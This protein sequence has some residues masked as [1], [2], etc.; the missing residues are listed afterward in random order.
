MTTSTNLGNALHRGMPGIRRFTNSCC[1]NFH[2][3]D[4]G[5][6]DDDD[7]DGDN[8]DDGDGNDDE[9]DGDQVGWGQNNFNKCLVSEGNLNIFSRLYDSP[10]LTM[11]HVPTYEVA[12][13]LKSQSYHRDY[14]D[15]YHGHDD[16]CHDDHCHDDHDGCLAS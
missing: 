9:D 10:N 15:E 16:Q 4:G 5:D 11:S 12:K 1:T 13:K 2:C 14:D 3:R 6:D 7:D 8:D